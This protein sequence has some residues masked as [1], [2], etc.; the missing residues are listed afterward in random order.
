MTTTKEEVLARYPH[1]SA[2]W[3]PAELADDVVAVWAWFPADDLSGDAIAAE[4]DLYSSAV[5]NGG[6]GGGGSAGAHPDA[7]EA[8]LRRT[9]AEVL[10]LDGACIRMEAA[11][12]GYKL[13]EDSD[14]APWREAPAYLVRA[15]Q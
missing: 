14:A 3:V 10:D 7:T 15:S 4:W 9:A 6:T 5:W 2:G 12:W 1:A 8:D 11:R 13:R